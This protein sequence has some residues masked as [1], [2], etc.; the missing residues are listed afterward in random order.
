M[1]DEDFCLQKKLFLII[2]L[3]GSNEPYTQASDLSDG[4]PG[5]RRLKPQK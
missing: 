2:Y 5:L 3:L 1:K 4:A